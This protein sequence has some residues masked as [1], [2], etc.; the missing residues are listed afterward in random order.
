MT[1]TAAAAVEGSRSGGRRAG[2]LDVHRRSAMSALRRQQPSYARAGL[3]RRRLDRLRPQYSGRD[4]EHR[5]R[6]R[7]RSRTKQRHEPERARAERAVITPRPS[8]RFA[9]FLLRLAVAWSDC[10]AVAPRLHADALC[11]CSPGSGCDSPGYLRRRRCR[12]D[13]RSHDTGIRPTFSAGRE[14]SADL[15]LTLSK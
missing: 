3:P 2:F 7:Q 10:R 6:D 5:E 9:R 15:E 12:Y 1:T 4:P 13:D 11:G 8:R 14:Q